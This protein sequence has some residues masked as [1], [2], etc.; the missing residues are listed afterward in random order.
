[1]KEDLRGKSNGKAV[2][3]SGTV[4]PMTF[5][6]A[7]MSLAQVPAGETVEFVLKEGD[8]MREVPK[9]LKEEGHQIEAVRKDGD[10]FHLTV[11][12]LQ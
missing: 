10:H 9:S 7:R 2:D 12:K 4:C 11:R 8:Q 3:L 1:M 5:V 6:K